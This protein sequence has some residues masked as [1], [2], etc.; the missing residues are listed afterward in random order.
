MDLATAPSR[1]GAGAARQVPHLLE[2]AHCARPDRATALVF[3]DAGSRALSDRL[4]RMI[5][6]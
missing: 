6:G 4:G 5:F 1:T 2:L 3:E